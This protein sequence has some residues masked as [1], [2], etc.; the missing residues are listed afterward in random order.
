MNKKIDQVIIE[1]IRGD[2]AA[3]KDMEAVVNAANAEL[4][5]GGGVAGAIHRGAG[6][7]LEKECR[8]YAPIAPG[9]A[10]LTR[11]YELPNDVVIHCLGPVYGLDSPEEKLLGNCYRKALE[12]AEENSISS[13]AFPAISTGAFGYPIEEATKIV[14]STI[15]EIVPGLRNVRVIRFVLHSEEDLETYKEALNLLK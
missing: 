5:I 15:K 12:I 1:C 2:I 10:V 8:K 6:Q 4:Q 3:Q 14:F 13:I 11:A 9:E 7:K